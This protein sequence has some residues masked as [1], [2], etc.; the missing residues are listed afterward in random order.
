MK[1]SE[2]TVKEITEEELQEIAAGMKRPFIPVKCAE[3]YRDAAVHGFVLRRKSSNSLLKVYFP[4]P[5]CEEC[6]KTKT[7]IYNPDEWKLEMWL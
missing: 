4:E 3:C 2:F 6:A 7:A 1:N 5:L